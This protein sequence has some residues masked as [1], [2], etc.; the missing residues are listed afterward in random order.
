M[1]VAIDSNSCNVADTTYR[2]VIAR[3][4]K[5]P[6]DF[7]YVKDLSLPCTSLTYDFTNLSTAP[8]GK[9]F[10]PASFVWNYG[11]N[12]PSGFTDG[13]APVTHSYPD[14]RGHISSI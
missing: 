5:A 8:P 10:G 2:H 3:T 6:V 11:D 12:T 7:A 14:T 9:P 13:P 4:D 1:M